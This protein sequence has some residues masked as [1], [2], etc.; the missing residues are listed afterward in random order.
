MKV[1]VGIRQSMMALEN[2]KQLCFGLP[3]MVMKD[4][5]VIEVYLGED[6]A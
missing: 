2:G 6:Y 5:Q 1:L 4:K 3:Y